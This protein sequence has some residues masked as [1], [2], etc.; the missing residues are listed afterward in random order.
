MT[1]TLNPRYAKAVAKGVAVA[2]RVSPLVKT[3]AVL[4]FVFMIA[5]A[6]NGGEWYDPYNY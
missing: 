2:R 3:L 1:I 5:A 6:C 4:F